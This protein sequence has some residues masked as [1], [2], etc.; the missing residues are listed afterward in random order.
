MEITKEMVEYFINRTNQHIT[1]VQE[2]IYKL[3]AHFLELHSQLLDRARYHDISKFTECEFIPYI[4]LSWSKYKNLRLNDFEK[5][6]IKNAIE[7]HYFNNR[8]HPEH[9]SNISNMSTI[10]LLEMFADWVAMSQEFNNSIKDFMLNNIGIR[11]KFTQKQTDFL[12]K[13]IIIL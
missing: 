3:T 13:L 6:R 4:K 1:L 7:I 2:N 12:Q 5:E 9:F 11:W 8:H 10:D